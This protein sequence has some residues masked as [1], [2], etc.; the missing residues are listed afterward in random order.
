MRLGSGHPTPGARHRGRDAGLETGFVVRLP[1]IPRAEM[2]EA[3]S[4]RRD[5]SRCLGA[6]RRGVRA[7]SE[8]LEA[9][10]ESPDFLVEIV[11]ELWQ[12]Q[13]APQLNELKSRVEDDSSLRELA[14]RGGG[15][16][17]GQP[18]SLGSSRWG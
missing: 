7:L 11:Q 5:L 17:P 8:E 15:A 4:I 10:P 12:Q 6:F 2:S 14:V 16:R 13:V 1:S 3:L 9:V 18:A